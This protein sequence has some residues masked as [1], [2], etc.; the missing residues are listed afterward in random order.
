LDGE[1]YTNVYRRYYPNENQEFNSGFDMFKTAGFGFISS[2]IFN[3]YLAQQELNVV[4]AKYNNAHIE[5]ALKIALSKQGNCLFIGKKS[6]AA[7]MPQ[8][9]SRK[10]MLR[11]GYINTLRIYDNF[12]QLGLL[13]SDYVHREKR[14]VVFNTLPR[15]I[16]SAYIS[17]EPDSVKPLQADLKSVF[18]STFHRKLIDFY[19]FIAAAKPAIWLLKKAQLIYVSQRKR[20]LNA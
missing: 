11:D 19:Y 16:I 9:W 7:R 13:S 3:T 5:L 14:K 1:P 6:V 10:N 18:P 8:V 15:F 4:T 2:L 20:K 12:V 17:G